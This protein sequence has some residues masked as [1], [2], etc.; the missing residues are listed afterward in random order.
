MLDRR[1]IIISMMRTD[2]PEE[3]YEKDHSA[4][5]AANRMKSAPPTQ[6]TA[7]LF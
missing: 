5:Y 6:E 3:E 7:R 2:E 4:Q 1:N